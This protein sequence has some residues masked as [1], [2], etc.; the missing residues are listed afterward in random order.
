VPKHQTPGVQVC[1]RCENKAP[2]SLGSGTKLRSA[3]TSDGFNPSQ[4]PRYT[5]DRGVGG[6]GAPV[7]VSI[8]RRTQQKMPNPAGIRTLT[9]LSVASHCTIFALPTHM[10]E[11]LCFWHLY[12][13]F[14]FYCVS[15]IIRL[16]AEVQGCSYELELRLETF[17]IRSRLYT[18]N[19]IKT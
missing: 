6:G 10:N 18:P 13:Q 12:P 9:S 11:Y 19:T 4:N 2:R 7:S 15:C 17:Y 5:L 1:R 14:T 16:Y 3:S 8:W